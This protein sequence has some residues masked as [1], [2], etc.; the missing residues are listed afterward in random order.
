LE[1]IKQQF[2]FL[3][4][5]LTELIVSVSEAQSRPIW[6]SDFTIYVTGPQADQRHSKRA[7]RVSITPESRYGGNVIS[8]KATR[9]T[10]YLC[11]DF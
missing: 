5:I 1:T 11:R 7:A 6:I 3:L 9:V 4:R 10:T 8:I 2:S